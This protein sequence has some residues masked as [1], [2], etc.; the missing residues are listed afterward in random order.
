MIQGP[1]PDGVLHAFRSIPQFE[2]S[3]SK[4]DD[5]SIVVISRND[6]HVSFRD[7]ALAPFR[8]IVD[9]FKR[10]KTETA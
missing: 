1:D 6:E 8:V 10:F 7:N 2:D 5:V 9:I 3:I 4:S